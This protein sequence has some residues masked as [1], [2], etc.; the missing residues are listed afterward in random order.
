MDLDYTGDI[1]EMKLSDF[2]IDYLTSQGIQ[3]CFFVSGGAVLHLVD[4]AER[5]PSM[6]LVCSQHE[7][8]AATSADALS[9]VSR[10]ELGFCLTT[11]GPGAT[12]LLTGVCNSYFDSIPMLCITGQVASFRQRQSP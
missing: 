10:S 5:N 9:R 3:N 12:N 11:S 1:N 2:I 6:R 4:S 7:Q 8:A